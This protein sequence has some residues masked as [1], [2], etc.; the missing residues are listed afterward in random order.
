MIETLKVNGKTV[1]V[2]IEPQE[3]GNG[4]TIPAEYF[5]AYYNLE[6]PGVY[7]S[8]HEPEKQPGK[9][10]RDQNNEPKKFL[11][12][13]EAVEYAAEQLPAILNVG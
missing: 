2:V 7:S 13:V 8:S 10:L 9:L 5:L 3:T 4:R 11:S 12:P 1:W 6:D